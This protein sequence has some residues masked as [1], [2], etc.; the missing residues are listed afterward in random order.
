LRPRAVCREPNTQDWSAAIKENGKKN[1]SK[2]VSDSGAYADKSS[3][4]GRFLKMSG[5]IARGGDK[6]G[7]ELSDRKGNNRESRRGFVTRVGT[8]QRGLALVVGLVSGGELVLG[9]GVQGLEGVESSG[10]IR[11]E[12]Q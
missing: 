7:T 11:V 9:G 8:K 12:N 1:R 4:G 3:R 6:K 5:K 2:L 10:S